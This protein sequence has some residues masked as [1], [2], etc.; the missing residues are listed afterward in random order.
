M[1][2]YTL[3]S[4]GERTCLRI[5][6]DVWF[7]KRFDSAQGLNDRPGTEVDVRALLYTLTQKLHFNVDVYHD[8][9]FLKIDNIL[10]TGN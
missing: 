7:L 8:L 1:Q 6:G 5:I 2:L 9:T 3:E 4:R 10:E